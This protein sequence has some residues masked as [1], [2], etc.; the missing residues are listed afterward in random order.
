M[1]PTTR[2]GIAMWFPLAVVTTLFAGLVYGTVQQTYR[3]GADDPQIQMAEDDS[4]ALSAGSATPEQLAGGPKVDLA[5]SLA[6]YTTV[7]DGQGS[8]IAST[9]SLGG[10][11]PVP[12]AGVLETAAADGIDSVTWQPRA[13]VRSAIVVVRYD[14]GTVLVG[15]SLRSVEEREDDL[16]LIT[17]IA[18]IVTLIAAAVACFMGSWFWSRATA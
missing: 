11:V 17:A 7:F 10:S 3:N 15:R 1:N 18:L 8:V 2:R 5:R 13:D 16:L 9:A 12:P 4:A 14:G 6:P